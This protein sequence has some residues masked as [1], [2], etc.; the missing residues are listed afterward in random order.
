MGVVLI[1]LFAIAAVV[2][3]P[4]LLLFAFRKM[5]RD[6]NQTTDPSKRVKEI[7]VF[8]AVVG[9]CAYFAY[10]YYALFFVHGF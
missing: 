7:I 6:R 10:N 9:I 3:L 5:Y 1:P 4:L 2:L 8:V